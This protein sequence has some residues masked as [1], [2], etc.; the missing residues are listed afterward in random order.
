VFTQT[1]FGRKL[2][3]SIPVDFV[4]KIIEKFQK[5]QTNGEKTIIK[6]FKCIFIQGYKYG[7]KKNKFE[8][9]IHSVK[10]L[11]NNRFD[12]YHNEQKDGSYIYDIS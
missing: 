6:F 11:E 1:I 7:G 10:K 5:S 2:D 12:F 4:E 9:K 3:S 8:K